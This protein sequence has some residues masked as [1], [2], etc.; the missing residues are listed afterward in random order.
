MHVKLVVSDLHHTHL[1]QFLLDL[2]VFFGIL[3]EH[4]DHARRRAYPH[5]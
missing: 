5:N 2:L 1:I 4:L 3:A